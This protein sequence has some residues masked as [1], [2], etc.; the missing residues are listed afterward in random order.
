[1]PEAEQHIAAGL[2][3]A[4]SECFGFDDEISKDHDFSNGFYIWLTEDADIKYG[5]GLSRIYRECVSGAAVK[6]ASPKHRG[7]IT[8][9]SFY[10]RYTG[11]RGLPESLTEWLFL[12][13]NALAEAING[14]VFL[15]NVGAFTEIRNALLQGYPNDVFKKKL[16]ARLIIMAQSGQY[17]YKRCLSHGEVG[18]ARLAL[19]EFCTSAISALFLLNGKYMPY[20]KWSLRAARS[21]KTQKDTAKSIERLLLCSDEGECETLIEKISSD[22]AKKLTEQGISTAVGTFL[23][24]HAYSVFNSI[25]DR[26]LRSVHIMEG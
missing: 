10:M 4:G 14:E 13:E 25:A 17:N 12:P 6:S 21:L 22:I 7:V 19:S 3:G 1:M 2:V 16:A 9:D 5:V 20:Y 24:P 15:D 8:V 11:R 26:E 23:E 18:A